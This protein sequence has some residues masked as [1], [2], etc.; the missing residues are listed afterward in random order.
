MGSKGELGKFIFTRWC[1]DILRKER[2]RKQMEDIHE[3]LTSWKLK[4]SQLEGLQ[5]T[6]SSQGCCG[7][8]RQPSG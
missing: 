6:K 3:S 7:D 5:N 8:H 4:D 2:D 1:K